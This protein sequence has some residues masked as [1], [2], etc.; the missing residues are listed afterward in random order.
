[1]TRIFARVRTDWVCLYQISTHSRMQKYNS[2]QIK[3]LHPFILLRPNLTPNFIIQSSCLAGEEGGVKT[4]SFFQCCFRHLIYCISYE[5]FLQKHLK[6]LSV[7]TIQEITSATARHLNLIDLIVKVCPEV[8]VVQGHL[9][10]DSSFFKY[11]Y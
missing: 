9:G 3:T 2:F 4:R 6:T 11:F 5:F 10:T 1:M 7:F 8:T